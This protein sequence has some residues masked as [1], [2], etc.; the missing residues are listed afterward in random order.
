MKKKRQIT[1]QAN[2]LEQK[3]VE[4]IK[5]YHKR[6]SDSDI[7]RFLIDQEYEKIL[8]S[9]A[10]IVAQIMIIFDRHRLRLT[11]REGKEEV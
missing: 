9:N 1:L 11:G 8:K 10:T 2:E 5:K 6:N 7:L 3:K 4:R